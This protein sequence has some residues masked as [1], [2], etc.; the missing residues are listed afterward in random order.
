MSHL[1]FV[2]MLS[3]DPSEDLVK[4]MKALEIFLQDQEDHKEYCPKLE[5]E[6]PNI[7]VYREKM[8]SQLPK[9]CKKE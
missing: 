3:S 9:E 7:E 4:K 1:I 2:M 6:Q 5:W 8:E